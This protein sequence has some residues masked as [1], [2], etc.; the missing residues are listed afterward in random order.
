MIITETSQ[1]KIAE[2][3]EACKSQ[4]G[5][6]KSITVDADDNKFAPPLPKLSS[7][8]WPVAV[9]PS[10]I[11]NNTSEADKI[12]RANGILSII[13]GVSLE[14]K[15]FLDFG[16]GEGHVA[17]Q[18]ALQGA[19]TS[20]GYDILEQV[21]DHFSP[22][23]NCK[24]TTNFDFVRENGPYDRILLYDVLDHSVTENPVDVLKKCK[25][26]IKPDGEI[27]IR[28]HPWCSRHGTH[29][30]RQI[31]KAYAHLIF[32]ESELASMGYFGIPTIKIIHP[33]KTYNE[34]ISQAGLK[35]VRAG[36]GLAAL[37]EVYFRHPA[38]TQK[39]K[40]HW[41]NSPLPE[42]ASGSVYPEYPMQ[43]QF[44]D[45]TIGV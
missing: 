15:K 23:E 45:I 10:N 1:D 32:S 29:L 14:S 5:A 11:A 27:H 25:E 6:V 31:N 26:I 39:I 8:E 16:C 40:E 34:W 43:F 33:M 28:F 3:I 9:D 21:W 37:P 20:V 36:D 19:T 22:L 35:T 17:Y 13:V 38:L 4:I 30:Y 18:A 24:F 2:L 41:K 7:Q 42:Y 12:T 44:L